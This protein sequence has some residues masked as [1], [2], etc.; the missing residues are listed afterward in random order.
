[1]RLNMFRDKLLV[2]LG[3][4]ILIIGVLYPQEKN[5]IFGIPWTWIPLWLGWLTIICFKLMNPINIKVCIIYLMFSL[6]VL[7]IV[8]LSSV[9]VDNY[10]IDIPHLVDVFSV[11]ILTT[12]TSF[13]LLSG[14]EYSKLMRLIDQF[15]LILCFF[16][17]ISRILENDFSREGQF[18][19]LG[20]LTFS[21]YISIGVLCRVIHIQ[22]I[23]L[24][25]LALYGFALMMAD[26]KGPTLFLIITYLLFLIVNGK[27]FSFKKLS[28]GILMLGFIVTN[29]RVNLFLDEVPYAIENFSSI[30]VTNTEVDNN[31]TGIGSTVSG[32]L[33][34]IYAISQS[35]E[36]LS[37][38]LF[39]GIGPGQW[40]VVTGMTSI[41]YP[42][43]SI[44]E[45]WSEFGLLVLIIFLYPGWLAIKKIYQRNI[46]A[47]FALF[48]FMTTLTSGSVRD[49]RFFILFVLLT[50]FFSYIHKRSVYYSNNVKKEVHFYD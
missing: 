40:P 1:M 23:S 50:F 10:D 21:K 37:E 43:N 20:P 33:I 22:K 5:T 6:S 42:H 3:L 34:R 39:F 38:N 41:V 18:L 45:I 49:L 16:L 25:S 24:T 35:L 46:Y 27:V 8:F 2:F 14:V 28:V 12:L 44:L 17:L 29:E 7:F 31:T 48:A 15:C 36:I 11:L 19:G 30:T 32:T 13:I 47:Y 9:S 4:I 26:S